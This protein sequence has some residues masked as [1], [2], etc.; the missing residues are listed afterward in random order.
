[1]ASFLKGKTCSILI[2]PAQTP[3]P[4]GSWALTIKGDR[5]DMSDVQRR[6]G[7]V[8]VGT[9][10][11]ELE[12]TGFYDDSL[13]GWGLVPFSDVQVVLQITAT[14]SWTVTLT[15]EVVAPRQTAK[16]VMELRVA[17]VVNSD[18]LDGSDASSGFTVI[19][20]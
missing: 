5:V 12:L 19:T 20:L 4:F 10:F 6:A 14:I 8:R 16:G 13:G 15:I 17:G 9:P 1:V 3:R 18:W 7:R 11:A 2:G